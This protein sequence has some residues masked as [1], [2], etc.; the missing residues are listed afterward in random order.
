MI[1]TIM[2]DMG[3]V[4]VHTDFDTLYAKFA[5]RMR[6]PARF[7][8]NFL[9]KHVADL[10]LGRT[11]WKQFQK[12]MEKAVGRPLPNFNK[13][14]IEQGL[15]VRTNNE[16]LL[17]IIATLRKHY[18]VGVVTNLTEGRW[19]IDKKTRVYTNFDYTVLSCRDHV[20]KPDPD[21]FHLALAKASA[22]PDE[23]IL[24]DNKTE[25]IVGAEDLGIKTITYSDIAHLVKDLQQFGVSVW[26]ARR[27]E[28]ARQTPTNPSAPPPRVAARRGHTARQIHR[29]ASTR[30]IPPQPKSEED[31]LI[32]DPQ[33]R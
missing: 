17:E 31:V 24:V 25:Y 14:W 10:T 29:T 26:V 21:F 22:K 11:P 16:P 12:D 32:P 6:I 33:Y 8:R 13:N 4:V 15:K 9:S 5:S 7:V 28:P 1:K 20:K 30:R 27:T 3:G 2:F 23:A 19:L 18:S